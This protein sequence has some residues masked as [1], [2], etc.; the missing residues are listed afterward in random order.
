MHRLSP[1]R[2]LQGN[3]Q[4]DPTDP[5][6]VTKRT[7]GLT[8]RHTGQMSIRRRIRICTSCDPPLG[9]K[10]STSPKPLHIS[11]PLPSKSPTNHFPV[12]RYSSTSAFPAAACVAPGAVRRVSR[13]TPT[14]AFPPPRIPTAPATDPIPNLI[15]KK[16]RRR[17][18]GFSFF[19]SGLRWAGKNVDAQGFRLGL[20]GW[21]RLWAL[22]QRREEAYMHLLKIVSAM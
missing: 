8:R 7:V 20:G 18:G 21:T 9:P 1:R 4:F 14:S 17:T 3:I 15:D 12:S 19:P 11:P 16:I 6:P 2:R 5:S 10:T 13:D 22:K